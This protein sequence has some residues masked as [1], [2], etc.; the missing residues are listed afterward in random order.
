MKE[1]IG[2]SDDDEEIEGPSLAEQAKEAKLEI[3]SILAPIASKEMESAIAHLKKTYVDRQIVRGNDTQF[4][5]GI[6]QGEAN[7]VL[8][9]IMTI[10][11]LHDGR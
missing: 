11:R 5:A 6:R 7:V 2:F 8:D 4:E 9:L 10:E 1:Y 3:D